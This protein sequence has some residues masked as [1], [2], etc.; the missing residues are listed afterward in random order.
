[1]NRPSFKSHILSLEGL[2]ILEDTVG[3]KEGPSLPTPLPPHP[4]QVDCL[5]VGMLRVPLAGCACDGQTRH[6]PYGQREGTE[7]VLLNFSS[8]DKELIW[9]TLWLSTNV[10]SMKIHDPVRDFIPILPGAGFLSWLRSMYF[11]HTDSKNE[12]RRL[13]PYFQNPHV[14]Y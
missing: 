3:S 1:M 13:S 14:S 4:S 2:L 7:G 11:L 5:D 9:D 10:Y 12:C 6:C 8:V